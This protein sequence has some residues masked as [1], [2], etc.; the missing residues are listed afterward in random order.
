MSKGDPES[1]RGIISGFELGELVTDMCS[2]I[3]MIFLFGPF[4]YA[5]K[6]TFMGATYK[7][8]LLSIFPRFFFLFKDLSLATVTPW[9]IL[10]VALILGV[11][12]RAV[13]IMYNILPVKVLER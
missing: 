10:A 8:F 3:L 12:S 6:Y 1:N 13:F 7:E 5:L 4:F 2:G 9:L 11:V